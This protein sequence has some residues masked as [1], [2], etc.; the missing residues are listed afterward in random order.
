MQRVINTLALKNMEQFA[1]KKCLSL[2]KIDI[3]TSF[4]GLIL[5]DKLLS[6]SSE[7]LITKY[8]ITSYRTFIFCQS[9]EGCVISD[10]I[11]I[12]LAW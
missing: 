3:L 4:L 7:H 6:L 12:L 1:E 9:K 10:Q 11:C 5:V 2:Q 8:S